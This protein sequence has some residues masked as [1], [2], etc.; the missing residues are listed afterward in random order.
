MS[1]CAAASRAEIGRR[2][3]IRRRSRVRRLTRTDVLFVAHHTSYV[4]MLLCFALLCFA[5]RAPPRWSSRCSCSSMAQL[6]VVTAMPSSS[7]SFAYARKPKLQKRI[8]ARKAWPSLACAVHARHS[9]PFTQ[10]I[11]SEELRCVSVLTSAVLCRSTMRCCWRRSPLASWCAPSQLP[12]LVYLTT[13][14]MDGH[15]TLQCTP[16]G[17]GASSA[18]AAERTIPSSAFDFCRSPVPWLFR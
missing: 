8:P 12:S 15:S 16:G 7:T 10:P 11:T 3:R 1:G 14:L 4:V 6:A 13:W 2:V 5:A 17:L 9:Q 18:A